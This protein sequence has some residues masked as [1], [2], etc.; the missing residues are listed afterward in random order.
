M[1]PSRVEPGSQVKLNVIFSHDPPPLYLRV[2]SCGT[3]DTGR[4]LSFHHLMLNVEYDYILHL[5]NIY[6]I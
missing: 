1:L 2:P 5:L 6:A 3:I 4:Y